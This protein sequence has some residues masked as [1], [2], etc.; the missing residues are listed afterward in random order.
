MF[1]VGVGEVENRLLEVLD[2]IGHAIGLDI[3]SKA[4]EVV[5]GAL[6]MGG[7]DNMLRVLP[8]VLG[9]LAPCCLDGG[10]RVGE[11]TVLEQQKRK[12]SNANITKAITARTMSNRTAS[13]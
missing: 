1:V 4:G 5:N 8:D 10:N 7:R 6:A 11:S 9:D 2:L 3:G 13:A 12:F